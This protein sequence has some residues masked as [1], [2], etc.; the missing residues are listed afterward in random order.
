MGETQGQNSIQ[1][2]YL[3]L[4][5]LL[6]FRGTYLYIFPR[7][8]VERIV[9]KAVNCKAL[10]RDGVWT[11]GGGGG[12]LIAFDVQWVYYSV[13]FFEQFLGIIC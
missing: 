4:M 3:Y 11:V 8:N 10:W 2:T 5:S 6:E 7:K 9:K 12:E 1:A 13:F